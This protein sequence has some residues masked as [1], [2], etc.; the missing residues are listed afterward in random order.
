[1]TTFEERIAKIEELEK[2]RTG[3]KWVAHRTTHDDGS[4]LIA[5]DAPEDK[6]L[7][8][9]L[10]H[11]TGDADSNSWHDGEYVAMTSTEIRFLLESV[12]VMQE[13]MKRIGYCVCGALA[14]CGVF[15]HKEAREALKELEELAKK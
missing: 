3:G 15:E 4:W 9:Y 7:S 13:K 12:K 10:W 14:H 5:I 8:K 1:M 11:H 6:N 2:K